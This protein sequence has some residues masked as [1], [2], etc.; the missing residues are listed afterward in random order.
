MDE[1]LRA[2][3]TLRP[4]DGQLPSLDAGGKRRERADACG[5]R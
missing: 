1:R 4:V 5:R 3:S 2:K